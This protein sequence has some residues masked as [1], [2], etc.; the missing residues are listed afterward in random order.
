M[1]IF[2]LN[3]VL[4]SNKFSYSNKGKVTDHRVFFAVMCKSGLELSIQ[5]SYSHYCEPRKTGKAE[6]YQSF[7]IGYPSKPVEIL[8]E[9]AENIKDLCDTVYGWVP[10]S[11]V[12]KVIRQN[13]GIVKVRNQE[14]KE[15]IQL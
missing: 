15:F 10:R 1:A 3:K 4:N 12:M 11:V 2:N 14:T 5:A 9:Y 7:E 13:G 8:R 6:I